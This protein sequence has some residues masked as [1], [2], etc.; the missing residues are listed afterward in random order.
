MRESRDE[1]K[2]LVASVQQ[3]RSESLIKV[4]HLAEKNKLFFCQVTMSTHRLVR[5][6]A[7]ST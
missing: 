5:G 6:R 2:N 4:Q 3:V 7:Y 1:N